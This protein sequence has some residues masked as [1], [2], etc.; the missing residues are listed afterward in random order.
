MELTGM[1]E[2]QVNT[3]ES[4]AS[5]TVGFFIHYSEDS[6]FRASFSLGINKIPWSTGRNVTDCDPLLAQ[7]RREYKAHENIKM[8]ANGCPSSIGLQVR[9]ALN[10]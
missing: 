2:F 6:I 9:N 7:M 5:C 4:P 8:D 10:L 1:L 3:T